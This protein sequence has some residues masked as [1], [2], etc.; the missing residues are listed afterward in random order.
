MSIQ[1]GS[2]QCDGEDD[3][4]TQKPEPTC[5]FLLAPANSRG[6]KGEAEPL[7][8]QEIQFHSNA[9]LFTLDSLATTWGAYWNRPV[10][11]TPPNTSREAQE[12]TGIGSSC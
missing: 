9:M 5:Q 3:G 4:S 6:P 2:I 1:E 11:Y 7:K 10:K 12:K 8:D